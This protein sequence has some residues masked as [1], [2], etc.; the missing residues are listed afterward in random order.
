MEQFPRHFSSFKSQRNIEISD[1]MHEN[2]YQIICVNLLNS[3]IVLENSIAFIIVCKTKYTFDWGPT[4]VFRTD[5]SD[6]RHT[7]K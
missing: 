3:Y 5:K 1:N 2:R 4:D 6:P 7:E